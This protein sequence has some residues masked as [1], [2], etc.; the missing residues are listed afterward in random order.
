MW[1]HLFNPERR[2]EGC[3]VGT[4]DIRQFVKGD[5]EEITSSAWRGSETK[6]ERGFTRGASG[7]SS[8]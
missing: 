5:D 6:E 3:S 4:G 7:I 8:P 1:P 2:D